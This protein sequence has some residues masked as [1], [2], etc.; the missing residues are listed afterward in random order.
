M[1]YGA[2][3]G[4]NADL[5][6]NMPI[7]ATYTQFANWIVTKPQQIEEALQFAEVADTYASSETD[8]GYDPDQLRLMAAQA[9]AE[10]T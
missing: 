4:W 7:E 10:A 6:R 3:G 2:D 5:S 9:R 1:P 8:V